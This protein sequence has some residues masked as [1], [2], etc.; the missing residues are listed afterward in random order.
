MGFKRVFGKIGGALKDG[1]VGAGGL[2]ADANDIPFANT[3]AGF[4]PIAGPIL[5]LAMK[6]AQEAEFVFT[7]RRRGTEKMAW[8]VENLSGDLEK[9][10]IREKRIRAAIEIALLLV[11]NEAAIV[12][13]GEA[14]E[15]IVSGSDK[16]EP[17][18]LTPSEVRR[19]EAAIELSQEETNASEQDDPSA[20][21]DG[22]ISDGLD[23]DDGA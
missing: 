9:L 15:D 6:R 23:S 19:V 12:D 8:A 11:K 13:I 18:E 1:I 17:D 7:G 14:V 20:V 22:D 4:V 16:I 2:L 5:Q 3:L 10:G 21:V